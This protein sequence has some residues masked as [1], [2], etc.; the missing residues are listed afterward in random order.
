MPGGD[1]NAVRCPERQGFPKNI[2]GQLYLSGSFTNK[3]YWKT[4]MSICLCVVQY[5]HVYLSG[6]VIRQEGDTE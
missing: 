5:K 6:R 1:A 2:A 3:I 4:A